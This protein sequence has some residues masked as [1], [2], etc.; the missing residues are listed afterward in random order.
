MIISDR[1]DSKTKFDVMLKSKNEQ[2][3]G[4]RNK[5]GYQEYDIKG[6]ETVV[7]SWK[8]PNT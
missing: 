4:K 2:L 1:I 8:R 3:P 5:A 7:V 6:D